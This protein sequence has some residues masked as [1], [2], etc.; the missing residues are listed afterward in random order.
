MVLDTIVMVK[1]GSINLNS[2]LLNQRGSTERIIMFSH[3]YPFE[4]L[5]NAL[6]DDALT[7]S[8]NN[9]PVIL[10]LR[11][12]MV[13]CGALVSVSLDFRTSCQG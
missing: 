8:E 5:S 7:L 12:K 4:A 1:F 6:K 2:I 11:N 9:L 13:R 3:P 10:P